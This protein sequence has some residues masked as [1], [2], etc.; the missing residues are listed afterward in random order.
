MWL[1]SKWP[2]ELKSTSKQLLRNEKEENWRKG[3]KLSS[4]D[5]WIDGTEGEEEQRDF[6]NKNLD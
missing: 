3:R 5:E 2:L 1:K 6:N 4:D